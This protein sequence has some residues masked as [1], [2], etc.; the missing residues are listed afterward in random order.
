MM[1]HRP[2]KCPCRLVACTHCGNKVAYREI[3]LHHRTFCERYLVRCE[4]ITDSSGT[5]S[6]GCGDEVPR[7]RL[8]SHQ[9]DH[10]PNTRI[11]CPYGCIEPMRRNQ[12][13]QHEEQSVVIHLRHL[14]QLIAQQQPHIAPRRLILDGI[15]GKIG[16]AAA[17]G[18][19]GAGGSGSRSGAGDIYEAKN[20]HRT[21]VAICRADDGLRH[22]RG[23]EQAKCYGWDGTCWTPLPSMPT[24]MFYGEKAAA[25]DTR[26]FVADV[27]NIRVLDTT[28]LLWSTIDSPY[29][30]NESI[31]ALGSKLYFLDDCA[32]SA[33]DTKAKSWKKL[34]KPNWSRIAAATIIDPT[35]KDC[36]LVF[37]GH[38]SGDIKCSSATERY[39]TVTDTWTVLASAP[40]AR[41]RHRA[42]TNRDGRI[43]IMGGLVDA[44]DAD[45]H[46]EEVDFVEEYDPVA[47]TW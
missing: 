7:G 30:I 24:R 20:Q 28:T 44:V 5:E 37:G 34:K 47:N 6:K 32:P 16:T 15:S 21:C 17:G 22:R 23:S 13:A 8:A 31:A 39:N 36:L 10:C 12:L 45:H 19:G 35:T 40:V 26:V 25:I 46:D 1:G 4:T 14:F 33:Y 43:W 41:T 9:R 38:N 11:V 42:V 2:G 27:T 3:D 29:T 18:A